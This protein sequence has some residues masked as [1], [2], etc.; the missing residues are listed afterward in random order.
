MVKY[1]FYKLRTKK[2]ITVLQMW[3]S[4]E[5]M[6]DFGAYTYEVNVSFFKYKY[7]VSGWDDLISFIA[8]CMIV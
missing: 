5:I 1:F 2:K 8:D 7:T 4:T 6:L 3:N